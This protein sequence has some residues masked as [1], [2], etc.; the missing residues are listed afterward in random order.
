MMDETMKESLERLARIAADADIKEGGFRNGGNTMA[1]L[2]WGLRIKQEHHDCGHLD[3]VITPG[4]VVEAITCPVHG[5]FN[6]PAWVEKP[7]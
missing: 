6:A 1:I 7:G 4:S 2:A 5:R 3:L